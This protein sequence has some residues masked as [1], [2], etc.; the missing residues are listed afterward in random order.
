MFVQ[1]AIIRVKVTW[2]NPIRTIHYFSQLMKISYQKYY[3][4]NIVIDSSESW[5]EKYVTNLMCVHSSALV[6][7][8]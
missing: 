1:V 6:A 2:S 5:N 7:S 3:L 8:S 4:I